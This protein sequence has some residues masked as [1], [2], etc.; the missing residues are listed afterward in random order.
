VN[1][2]R[3]IGEWSGAPLKFVA[4]SYRVTRIAVRYGWLPGARYTNLR[5][6]RSFD[7][8]G[9]LDIVWDN[10]D[11]QRHLAATRSTRPLATVAR[12]IEDATQLPEIC[13]QAD[14]LAEYADSVILVPKDRTLG[15]RIDDLIPQRFLLG[16][17]VPT[18]YG[19]TRIAARHFRRPVH[20]LGG[21][22]E[23]QRQLA[24]IMPVQSLDCNRFT[25]DASFGDYFDGQI[26]RPHPLGGYD[27]CIRDSIRNITAL[28]ATYGSGSVARGAMPERISNARG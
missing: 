22:P 27:T 20:L 26:F 21:R 16:Y 23:I 11:F 2:R 10:Y 18:R 14:R 4:Y 28:W 7:R 9:F 25:L 8:L 24:E 1:D 5:D 3:L 17:S 13:E 6:I 19:G 12:D 15:P